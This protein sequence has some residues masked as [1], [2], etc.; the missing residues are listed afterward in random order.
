M[1]PII[2]VG[3][4][5]PAT[6][7]WAI[8]RVLK[9]ARA[10]LSLVPEN[11]RGRVVIAY[12]PVW[13]IGEGAVAAEPAHIAAL[14]TLV[15]AA[16]TSPLGDGA[17]PIRVFAAPFRRETK[18]ALVVIA[19]EIDPSALGLVER[20]RTFNGRL[21]LGFLATD[22]RGKVYQGKHYSVNLGLKAETYEIA[23][24]QGLRVLSEMRLAPGRYQLRLAAGNPG[25]IAGNVVYDL[26]VPDFS[27]SPLT[28]GGIALTSASTSGAERVR[29][30]PATEARSG[31]FFFVEELPAGAVLVG[32]MPV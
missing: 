16:L 14:S 27:A 2:C 3:E 12:E 21:E 15:S 9:Q 1:T 6:S 10:A 28:L 11:D 26:L 22:V 13:A 31:H 7:E 24:Q 32:T 17:V 30:A 20:D 8:D 23:R 29:R 4:L 5:V 25:G 19:A 18:A